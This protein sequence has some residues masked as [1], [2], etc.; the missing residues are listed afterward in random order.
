MRNL[1]LLLIAAAAALLTLIATMGVGIS[2]SDLWGLLFMGLGGLFLWWLAGKT[3]DAED[4]S[5]L[6]RVMVATVGLRMGWSFTQHKIL[7]Q[8]YRGI[9]GEDTLGGFSRGAAMATA[10]HTGMWRPELPHTLQQFHGWTLDMKTVALY[11]LFGPSWFLNEAFPITANASVCIAIYLIC[12]HIG[13]TRLSTRTAAAFNAFLPSLIFWSTQDLRDPVLA[14]CAA[15][16]LLALL[17]TLQLGPGTLYL[18]LLVLMDLLALVYRPYAGIL[19]TTGLGMAVVYAVKLPPTVL[20]KIARVWVFAL[21]TPLVVWLGT[22]EMKATYGESMG[23][24]W[25]AESYESFRTDPTNSRYEIPITASTPGRAILQLPIRIVLLLLTPMPI[26]PGSFRRMLTYPEMWFLYL[27]VVP[28]FVR[29][30]RAAWRG[31]PMGTAAILLSI[32]PWVVAQALKTA[33]SGE[34]VRMRVQFVPELLIFA[35]VG[36]AVMEGRKRAQQDAVGRGAWLW[37]RW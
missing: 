32:G 35:G 24:Q 13:T 31:N 36:H 26:F 12:R 17:K 1:V 21:L 2:L 22:K 23:V 20:A 3:A 6:Q 37:Q 4:R 25:A 5:F 15:W 9:F 8:F 33:L 19:L 27:Y 18:P 7:G 10:W 34:A 29:G 11:Y 30:M 14:T 28:R 16:S